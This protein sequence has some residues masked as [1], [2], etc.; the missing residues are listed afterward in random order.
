[1]GILESMEWGFLEHLFEG[2]AKTIGTVL[3]IVLACVTLAV[4]IY[5][6]RQTNTVER[7][8]SKTA[9]KVRQELE[10]LEQGKEALRQALRVLDEQRAAIM[11]RQQRLDNVRTA[12][13]GKEQD[14]WC[15]HRAKKLD[16]HARKITR[17]HQRPI[18]MVANFKGGVGKT[19]LAA[20]LAAHFSVLGKRVLLVDVDYQGSLS[21]MLLSADGCDKVA[22]E[23]N[24]VLLPGASFATAS[25]SVRPFVKVLKGSSLIASKYEFASLENRVMIE[26]LLQDHQDDGRY[27]LANLL[28]SSEMDDVFDVAIIDAPPRLTAGTV[29]AF[30]ASTHLLVPTVYDLLSAEAVGTFLDSARTLKRSLNHEIDLLGV[31]GMLTYQQGRLSVREENAKRAAIRQVSKT[32]SANHY[33]FKRHIPR[34]AEI[35]KAAGQDLAYFCDP[36][37]RRWF[38]SLGAEIAER[39]GWQVDT[40]RRRASSGAAR[41]AGAAMTSDSAEVRAQ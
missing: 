39:L 1:M 9:E 32:W 33:F 3:A 21:N 34:K 5:R 11:A 13:I 23:I 27:R 38:D 7:I 31:V 16:E 6:Y 12:F 25:E 24:K 10:R 18:I 17:Q 37:V 35:A 22:A 29:N 20:N 4:A 41:L 15:L 36:T 28:L 40:P 19:T 30:C 14:L 2:H 8:L 26:Y